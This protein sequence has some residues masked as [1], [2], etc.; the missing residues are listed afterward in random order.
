MVRHSTCIT[1]YSTTKHSYALCRLRRCLV[2][3][4]TCSS[5]V[6]LIAASNKQPIHLIMGFLPPPRAAWAPTR[7]RIKRL[8]SVPWT[9]AA[10]PT[11]NPARDPVRVC[12]QPCTGSSTVSFRALYIWNTACT[13]H[14]QYL[15]RTTAHGSRR[16]VHIA[17]PKRNK[18]P[19]STTSNVTFQLQVQ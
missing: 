6:V 15:Y 8:G 18:G 11:S 2:L 13:L 7:Q 14:I 9:L 10:M 17:G 12:F 1:L 3:L 16:S 4:I 5:F 19:G